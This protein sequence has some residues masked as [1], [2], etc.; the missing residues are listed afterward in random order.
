MMQLQ[1]NS[2]LVK[3]NQQLYCSFLLAQ[4]DD[5]YVDIRGEFY[6]IWADQ[7]TS[8]DTNVTD[9]MPADNIY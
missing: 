7:F 9:P 2:F 3:R 6:R 1:I 5:Q 4:E 8:T